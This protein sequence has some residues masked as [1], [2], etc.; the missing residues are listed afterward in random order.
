MEPWSA[1]EKDKKIKTFSYCAAATNPLRVSSQWPFVPN[2]TLSNDAKGG[3]E[4]KPEAVN[5]FPDI[6]KYVRLRKTPID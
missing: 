3:N 2:V 6:Y 1:A 4:A 5:I